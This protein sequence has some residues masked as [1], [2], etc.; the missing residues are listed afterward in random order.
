MTLLKSSTA[1]EQGHYN[2]WNSGNNYPGPSEKPRIRFVLIYNFDIYIF[3][4]IN[5]LNCRQNKLFDPLFL[6]SKEY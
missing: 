1:D 5:N 6:V 4:I 3:S 2:E